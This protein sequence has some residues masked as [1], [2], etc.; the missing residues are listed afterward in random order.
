MAFDSGYI[1]FV[2]C[3]GLESLFLQITFLILNVEKSLS[4]KLEL[5]NCVH[6][7]NISNNLVEGT[8]PIGLGGNS[9][10]IV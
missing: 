6:R 7:R 9:L 4:F 2:S 5:I 10:T 1:Y 3:K 8:I